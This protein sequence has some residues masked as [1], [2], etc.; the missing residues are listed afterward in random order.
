VQHARFTLVT[1]LVSG[2]EVPLMVGDLLVVR[3]DGND[4]LDWELVATSLP[5]EAYEREPHQ[6]TMVVLEGSRTLA[7]DAVVVRS[8]E[9]RHVFRG[10]GP[11]SGLLDTDLPLPPSF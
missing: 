3:H 5:V 8:D 2:V 9:Q 10:M 4:E 1:L 7:G 11:L 6:L